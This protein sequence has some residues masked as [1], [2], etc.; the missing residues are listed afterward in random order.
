MHKNLAQLTVLT[1]LLIAKAA[2]AETTTDAADLYAGL[3]E[4]HAKSLDSGNGLLPL[5]EAIGQRRFVLLGESSHGTHEF[6]VWRD[7]ITRHLIENKGFDFVAVEGDWQAI[8]RLNDYVALRRDHDDGVAGVMLELDRWPQWLWANEEFADF[9]EWLRDH[10]AK[11]DPDERV[12]L[13]GLDLQDPDNSALAVLEWFEQHKGDHHPRIEAA[14][15]HFLSLPDTFAGY[16]AHLAAGG[17]RLNDEAALAVDLLEQD[18]DDEL[19]GRWQARQNAIAVARF[20]QYIHDSVRRG[21]TAGWNRRVEHFHDTF[22]QVA[23]QYGGQSRGVAWAHNTHVGDA[24]ATVMHGQGQLNIGQLLRQSEQEEQVFIIGFS[25]HGGEVMAGRESGAEREIFDLPRARSGSV[26][27]LMH[28]HAPDRALLLF[29]DEI[30]QREHALPLE[31]RALGVTFNPG[32]TAY[33]PSLLPWR[34]DALIHI[35]RTSAL[36]PLHP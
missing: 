17:D 30:R 3:I 16:A 4:E 34:Y 19:E 33:V 31:H 20:E 24:R 7:R 12:G 28:E 6:Y 9:C 29:G 14:Y 35:D 23:E 25:T 21:G 11:R 2:S 22:L 13:Y 36:T 32:Q 26:E 8:R 18:A 10:N 15:R 1:L 5:Y 27:A